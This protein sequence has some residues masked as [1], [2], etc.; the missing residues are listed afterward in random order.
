MVIK[1]ALQ[2][3]IDGIGADQTLIE[4]GTGIM[5]LIPG[6]DLVLVAAMGA[7]GVLY[8]A[9]HSGTLSDYSDATADAS[10]WGDVRCAIFAAIR[11][12]GFVTGDN[13][14]AVQANI[15]GVA[16]AHTDVQ[17]AIDDYVAAIGASGLEA[18]QGAGSLY[19]GDCSTCAGPWCYFFDF[20]VDAFAWVVGAYGA[21]TP[22]TGFTTTAY[23]A[24]Q[25]LQI[26][27]DGFTGTYDSV[28]VIGV[29]GDGGSREVYVQSF[30]GG[31]SYGP[32]FPFGH[33]GAFDVV[34]AVG[35]TFE[36]MVIL[37]NNNAGTTGVIS[38]LRI[39]GTGICPFGAPNC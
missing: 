18:V 10:L 23:G 37:N 15:A 32:L 13:F 26:Q 39:R 16:Y 8:S 31:N 4:Y 34:E 14:A 28:E 12:A 38:G 5:A 25:A 19:V 24:Y 9:M 11:E 22:G 21:Y 33:V 1:Q 36:G 20:T 7:L 17:N 27:R 29:S 6:V 35:A 3:A 2:K 30:D